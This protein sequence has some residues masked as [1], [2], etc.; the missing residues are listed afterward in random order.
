M[1]TSALVR[2]LTLLLVFATP[3][4]LCAQFQQPTDEE[5]KMTADPKAPGAAAVYLNIEEIDNDPIHFKSIYVRIKVLQEKGKELATVEIPYERRNFKVTDIMARTIHS[6]GTVIPLVGKPEELLIAKTKSREG[7]PLQFSRTV[8]NLPSVEVGSILEYR[9]EIRYDDDLSSSPTWEIQRSYFVHHAR[10]A[11]TPSKQFLP[12]LQG[13]TNRYLIDERGRAINTLIW[14][15]VLPPNVVMDKADVAGV[16]HLELA[17]VPAIPDE[18]WMPPINGLL[19]HVTFYYKS[20]SSGTDF[21]IEE[22]RHWSKEVDHFAEPSKA[23]REAVAGIISPTDSDLEK[24]NKL[25]KAVQALD[26]TDFSRKKT[27]SELKQLKLKAARHAEDTWKQKSGSS[28]DIALLYLAMLRAAGLTAYDMKVVDRSERVFAIGFLNFDQL[29]DDIIVA[30]IAGKEYFLDPGEKMCPFLTLHW[31]HSGAT[32]IRQSEHIHAFGITPEQNYPDNKIVRSGDITL[33]EHGAISGN[34]NIIM[35]GQEALFWRQ[36][37]L[38]YDPDEV[39]KHF[40]RWLQSTVP[41]G[42]EAHIDHFL[43]MDDPES[44]LMAVVKVS[45]T[46]GASTAKRLLL[47]GFFFQTRGRQPFVNQEKRLEP[48]DMHFPDQVLDQITYHLPPGLTV[49]GAPPDNKIAWEGHAILN[50]KSASVPGQITIVRLLSRAFSTVKP[51]DYQALHDF[52]QKVSAADQAQLVLTKTPP[53]A[54]APAPPAQ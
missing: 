14:W 27:E 47:P 54:S 51:E 50:D 45:G 53:A 4:L 17:D 25:Y 28:E 16:Y 20:A 32:G 36:T 21:W 37:S 6:D 42:V 35:R 24:A 19:Y 34:M 33:D 26:N 52:Y 43:G 3:A 23:I 13:A 7:D 29:D 18:E 48:V 22:A 38:R 41:E 9:Y 40:D 31:K 46:L 11:F 30:T 15:P 1:R 10:Y 5:L 12:G 44:I 2:H 8:F 49:E 39:K